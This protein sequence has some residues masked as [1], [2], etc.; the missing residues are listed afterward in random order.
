MRFFCLF[1]LL[2]CCSTN[3]L[4]QDKPVPAKPVLDAGLC[5]AD[6]VAV[7]QDCR[8]RVEGGTENDTRPMLSMNQNTNS[9]A[10]ATREVRPQSQQLRPTEAEAFRARRAERLQA[11][12]VPY[13][14]CTR[15]CN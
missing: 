15:G 12:E 3:T 1:I 8:A 13:R 9:L 4:A 14:S 7:R 5:K 11:C 10:T 6:C 2:A